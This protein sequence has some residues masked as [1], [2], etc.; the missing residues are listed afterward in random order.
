MTKLSLPWR[1]ACLTLLGT[2]LAL[3]ADP[4][5]YAM[6]YD[7]KVYERDW[8][9]FLRIIGFAPTWGAIAIAIWLQERGDEMTRPRAARR[10]WSLVGAAI[11]G[12][13][14][15]EVLKLILR[16]E[17]PMLHDG[18]YGFRDFADRPFSTSGLAF[19]SSHTMVAFAGAAMLA[20]LFPRVRWVGYVLAAGCGI[21]RVMA[22]GHFVSDVV[23]AAGAG[24]L[25]SWAITRRW[26][27][28]G[29]R[30]HVA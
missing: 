19:P 5:G 22:R 4:W 21:T 17:R 2:A 18:A 29:D 24:W 10:A 27:P 14:G 3:L 25:V 28:R 16:R 9:R 26:P 15:A 23:L 6:L 11:A 12:G 30:T 13:A 8:G 1:I 20:Q 7:P